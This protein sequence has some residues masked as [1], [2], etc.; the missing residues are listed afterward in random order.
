MST[1]L[2]R[3]VVIHLSSGTPACWMHSLTR[4]R[5]AGH[6]WKNRP[7]VISQKLTRPDIYYGIEQVCFAVSAMERLKARRSSQPRRPF[8]LEGENKIK[9]LR[10]TFETTSSTLARCALQNLQLYTLPSR[11]DVKIRPIFS[12]CKPARHA[13]AWHLLK[14]TS[15][16]KVPREWLS[17]R[18]L[19][20]YP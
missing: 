6:D 18:Y 1:T 4:N 8:L 10:S 15:S 19:R 17:V 16:A 2:W 9:S 11:C 5:F 3:P 7:Y 13:V 12:R 20:A 14:G